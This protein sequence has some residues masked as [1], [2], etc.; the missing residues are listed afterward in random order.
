MIKLDGFRR[1]LKAALDGP[2]VKDVEW[3]KF[4]HDFNV[5]KAAIKKTA[6]G[7]S[8]DGTD[9]HHI[10]HR[11]KWRPDDQIY[12]K[13]RVTPQGKVEDL[14]VNIKSSLDILKEWLKTAGEVIGIVGGLIALSKSDAAG[15]VDLEKAEPTPASEELLDG[16]WKS[17]V[18]FLIANIIN[19]AVAREMPEVA[20]KPGPLPSFGTSIQTF[21]VNPAIVANFVAARERLARS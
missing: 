5:K 3:T 6:N 9:G 19:Y 21:R 8:I 18:E 13:C 2:E 10:S 20:N 14:E 12:Y 4:G 16:D 11:L 1:A 17:D 15:N 7:L